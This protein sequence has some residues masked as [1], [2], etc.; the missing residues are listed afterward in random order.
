MAVAGGGTALVSLTYATGGGINTLDVVDRFI[1]NF[2][3]ATVGLVEVVVV[4][5][6]LRELP[7]LRS[8]ADGVSDLKLGRWWL[9]SL[10]AI[11]P[12]VLGWMTIDNLRT[13]LTER[14]EGYP[15]TFLAI[16]GW[17]LAG[18]AMVVGIA[19][20]LAPWP[21]ALELHRPADA[22]LARPEEPQ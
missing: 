19:M 13:E 20:S 8:H 7:T 21:A 15:L 14:Y 5:W 4:A 9:V 18:L 22:R 2:G 11:T 12:I 1:N 3:V 17:G 6:L 16:F 10:G